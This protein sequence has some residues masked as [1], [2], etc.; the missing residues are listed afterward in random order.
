MRIFFIRH[1]EPDYEKDILT[2]RGK[3]QAVALSKRLEPEGLSE[4]YSS[5][6]GRAYETAL[7][8][9]ELLNLSIKKLDYMHEINWGGKDIPENG[10]PR[11]LSEWMINKENFD[12]FEK[13]WKEHPYY[14]NNFVR[15]SF[16]LVSANIDEF[17]KEK[18]YQHEGRRFLCNAVEKENVAIFSHGGSGACALSHL[19]SLPLPYVFTVL[20]YEFTSVAIVNFPVEH[21]EYVHP[22]LELFNDIH[23]LEMDDRGLVIQQNDDKWI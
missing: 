5:P 19:L 3:L 14:L 7:P 13:D 21:G 20:P 2:E 9:A 22:R 8:T 10:H 6:M 18:G 4:I 16:D 23:H 1:G 15:E 17:P 12:F 11:T